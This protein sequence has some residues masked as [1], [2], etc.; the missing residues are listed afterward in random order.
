MK[1]SFGGYGTYRNVMKIEGVTT[2][3]EEAQGVQI[4]RVTKPT[5]KQLAEAF[6]QSIQGTEN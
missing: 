4:D 3:G 1:D 2:V 6:E 5:G